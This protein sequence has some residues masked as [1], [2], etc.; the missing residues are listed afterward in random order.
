MKSW[1]R[2]LAA[3]ALAISLVFSTWP[4]VATAEARPLASASAAASEADFSTSS[5][6]LKY[7]EADKKNPN[8]QIRSSFRRIPPSTPNPTQNK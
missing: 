2:I 8:K 6:G 7:L 1:S 4:N 3:L 5:Q